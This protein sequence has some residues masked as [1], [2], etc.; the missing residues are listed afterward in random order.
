VGMA[1][2]SILPE[3]HLGADSRDVI[4]LATGLVVTMS[5]L[6][7]GMLVSSAKNSYDTQKTDMMQMAAKVVLLD[8][9]LAHYGPET[10]SSRNELRRQVEQVLDEIWPTQ[11]GK[12]SRLKPLEEGDRLYDTVE[13]LQP[14][15][16]EQGSFK[17]QALNMAVQIKQTR[18][19]LFIESGGNSLSIPLLIVVISWI[20]AVFISF[21]MFS[22]PN[23]TVILTL[24]I[25]ALAVS[26]AIFIIQEMYSPFTGLLRISSAP[27]RD[28]LDHIGR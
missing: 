11:R 27:I 9:M 24:V 12:R 20:T 2:Q 4:R 26:A 7:L 3:E 10:Q 15:N 19:V 13:H 14:A 1:L 17:T 18:L 8:N 21:G 22:P 6:V 5:A 28:A 23:A 16:E 25:C